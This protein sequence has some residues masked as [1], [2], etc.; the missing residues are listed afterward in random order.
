[1]DYLHYDIPGY[2]GGKDVDV[3]KDIMKAAGFEDEV[4][5]IKIGNCPLCHKKIISGSFRD[6]LSAKEFQI[7]GLCQRC[8]DEMFGGEF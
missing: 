7:S 8:Q 4:R 2:Y 6:A 3:N 1:L 5:E